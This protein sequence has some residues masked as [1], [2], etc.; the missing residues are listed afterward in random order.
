MIGSII[1][2]IWA[3]ICGLRETLTYFLNTTVFGK[4]ITQRYPEERRDPYPRFH[5]LHKLLRDDEGKEKCV[6][7]G[8]CARVCPAQCIT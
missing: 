6:A 1:K 3:L 8:L 2:D 5:G 4:P 7:C